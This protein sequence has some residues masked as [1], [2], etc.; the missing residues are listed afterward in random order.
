MFGG[1]IAQKS[2]VSVLLH[3]PCAMRYEFETAVKNHGGKLPA[4][5]AIPSLFSSRV[6]EL[7]YG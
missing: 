2:A 7:R 4:D 3:R 6:Y 1:G 5:L